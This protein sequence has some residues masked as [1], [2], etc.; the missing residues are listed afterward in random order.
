MADVSSQAGAV[1]EVQHVGKPGLDRIITNMA[2]VITDDVADD[3]ST[4]RQC[5]EPEV[6][7]ERVSGKV[8]QTGSQWGK[9]AGSG[10][11]E[12]HV[13]EEGQL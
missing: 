11:A 7:W 5:S 2:T 6:G 12:G 8:G 4:Y 13:L 3:V 10:G 9:V 1:H